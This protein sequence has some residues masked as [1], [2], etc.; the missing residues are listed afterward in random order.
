MSFEER[1]RSI[2]ERLPGMEGQLLTEE[3]TKN[4]LVLPFLQALGS[5]AALPKSLV[6][7]SAHGVEEKR[8]IAYDETDGC[9]P[10][11]DEEP[12]KSTAT[13]TAAGT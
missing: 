12:C 5:D 13:S 7:A 3:A 1:L 10:D 8:A 4:A 9:L 6:G 11:E 2:A